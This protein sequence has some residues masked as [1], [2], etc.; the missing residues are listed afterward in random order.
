MEKSLPPKLQCNAIQ[1][2]G[3]GRALGCINIVGHKML[4]VFNLELKIAWIFHPTHVVGVKIIF[5]L[6]YS[7][8]LFKLDWLDINDTLDIRIIK[9]II[10][11]SP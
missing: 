9:K 5:I 6:H 8:L 4:D 7:I 10:K 11:N 2:K 1:L 3:F